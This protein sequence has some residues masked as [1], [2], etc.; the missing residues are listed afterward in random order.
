MNSGES[1]RGLSPAGR[2]RQ[3]SGA[4]PWYGRRDRPVHQGAPVDPCPACHDRRVMSLPSTPPSLPLGSDGYPAAGGV[5]RRPAGGGGVGPRQPPLVGRRSAGLPRRTRRRPRGRRLPVVPG[6]AAGGRGTPARGRRRAAGAG[7]RLRL[8]PVRT[9]AAESRGRGRRARPLGRDA[10]PGSGAEPLHGAR[11][12]AGAGRRR[13]PP[14][15]GQRRSGLFGF[16]GLPFVAD[17][18]GALAEVARVLRP[19]GRF[20]ASVNHPL[21]WPFRTPPIPRT[22]GSSRPTSTARP[23]SRPTTRAGPSTWS[24]TARSATGYAPSSEPAWCSTT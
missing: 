2:A 15:G 12:P 8:G 23:T 9:L 3:T 20:V 14:S 5:D 18:E 17:V 11:R 10:R 24:T 19:G 1:R 4:F 22:C 21:R 6:G 7:D 16:G 13:R